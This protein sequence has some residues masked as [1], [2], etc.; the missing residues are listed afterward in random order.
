MNEI[1]TGDWIVRLRAESH[2]REVALEISTACNLSCV[3]CFRKSAVRFNE[4]HMEM[5]IF[6]RVLRNVVS[7]GV[8]R[9]ALTGWGEPST[10]PE[11]EEIIRICRKHG[12]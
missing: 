7:A 8:R 3:H 1:V 11:I 4:G 12:L 6:R 2:P 10:H 9:V 5:D